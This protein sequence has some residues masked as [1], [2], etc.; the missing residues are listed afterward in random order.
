MILF[1]GLDDFVV[2]P[3]QS[4]EM[5]RALVENNVSVAYKEFEGEGHGFRQFDTLVDT[6]KHENA[7]YAH[8]LGLQPDEALPDMSV[9]MT[10]TADGY[11][12]ARE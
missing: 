5:V 1:Q 12:S 4:R 3:E 9:L 2:P 10:Q 11:G 7:F 6:L 8:V